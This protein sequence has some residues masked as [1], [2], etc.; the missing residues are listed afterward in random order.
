MEPAQQLP[1]Q[2]SPTPQPPLLAV[3]PA[4]FSFLT[5]AQSLGAELQLPVIETTD[6]VGVSDFQL[7][8]IID[9]A[10]IGL[11]QTGPKPPGPVRV[12][13]VAGQ[14]A[15][16]RKFGGGAGQQIA[17]AVGLKSGVRP[18]VAD[19]TAGLGRDAFVLATL[20]CEVM[21]VERSPIIATLLKDGLRRAAEHPEVAPIAARM[22]LTH[23]DGREWLNNQQ[24]GEQA[25]HVVYVDPMFPHSEKSAEVKK[26]MRLFRDL[27]GGDNDAA[28]L[29]SAALLAAKNRVVVKRPRKAPVIEGPEPGFAL[30]GKSGRFDIYP[31]KALVKNVA[32]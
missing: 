30:K 23:G 22:H 32:T 29:L 5:E 6:P 15:H 21:M 14:A 20:G 12:D 24:G 8:L 26:E 2:E 11:Q 10:G 18:Y 28:E 7:L 3:M 25:P 16:R 19:V 1:I 17:K 31:L 9:E 27:I 13:F 4:S